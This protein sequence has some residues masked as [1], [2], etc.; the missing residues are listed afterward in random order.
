MNSKVKVFN[1]YV[2]EKIEEVNALC[3]MYGIPFFASFCIDDN[4][5]T[6][7]YENYMFGSTSNGIQLK[8]DRIRKHINVANGFYTVPPHASKDDPE[9]KI[10]RMLAELD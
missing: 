4:K 2:R 1:E 10:D 6:S 8:D 3:D 5:E 7:V 9:E